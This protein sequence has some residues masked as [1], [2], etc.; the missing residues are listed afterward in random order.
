MHIIDS[1]KAPDGSISKGNVKKI[2]PYDEPF[3]FIDKVIQLEK[4]KIIAIKDVR[5]DEG[6]FRGHFVDF[7]IM[8]GALL[9]EGLG[10]AATMVARYNI[11]NHE[12]KD[13]L[14]YKI[15]DVKFKEPVFPGMQVRYEV[16]LIAQDDRGAVFKGT[17]YNEDTSYNGDIFIAEALL[18]I[19]I[20]NKT[21]FRLKHKRTD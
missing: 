8:P 21:E 9:V 7:P 13:V 6:F 14:A 5:H 3:L 11:T 20:V 12:D 17:V 2:I 18:V 16:N 4:D 10:Q 1:F 15:K 19:A